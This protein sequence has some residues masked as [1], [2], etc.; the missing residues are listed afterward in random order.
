MRL[1]V[2]GRL[3]VA[4]AGVNRW[5]AMVGLSRTLVVLSTLLLGAHVLRTGQ[6]LVVL[7]VLAVIPL[8]AVQR[9]WTGHVISIVLWIGTLEWLRTVVMR[10]QERSA[11]GQ[12]FGRMVI[13]LGSVAIVTAIAAV[14]TQRGPLGRWFRSGGSDSLATAR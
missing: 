9:P 12:P 4:H 13:I 14:L 3:G 8:L 5:S 6:L 11:L 10:V 1:W 2:G 7:L